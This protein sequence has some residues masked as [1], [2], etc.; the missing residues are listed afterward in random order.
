MSCNNMKADMV[1]RRA[2]RRRKIDLHRIFPR[3]RAHLLVLIV[4]G[5]NICATYS[6][7]SPC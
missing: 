3:D 7:D 5:S 6:Q 2:D 1:P 4:N